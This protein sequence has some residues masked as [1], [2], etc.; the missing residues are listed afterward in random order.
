MIFKKIAAAVIV[1]VTTLSMVCSASA[2]TALYVGSDLT[3]DG[4][5]MFG[6]IEDLGTN[7]YNK[8]YYVSAAGKHKAGELYNGCYGFS[9]TFTHDSYSYT[10]RRDDNALGVCP[11]C[12]GTHDHT[13]YEEAG[14]NEKGVM[15][16]ATETLYGMKTVL[17]EDPYVDNGIEEAEITTVLLSEAATARE[18]VALLTSIYDTTGAAGGSG[19]FIADQNETWFVEN[20]TGHTY[21]ALKLSSS[22]AFM[23]PNVAAIGKIDLD[24]TENVVASANLVEVAQKAGTWEMPL[25]MSSI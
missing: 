20:L 24:D 2:C 4:T 25:P 7:D 8:L 10:A 11:D 17:A 9:Y 5:A 14:T 12:D 23:Q 16:S 15:V 19:V 22:V 18:G 6:R 1:T 21:I 3:E 13:P